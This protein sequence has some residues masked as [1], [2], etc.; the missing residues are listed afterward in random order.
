MV[1]RERLTHK[2]RVAR[3]VGIHHGKVINLLM[4]P[5]TQRKSMVP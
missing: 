5:Y 4:I 1:N 3:E 2:H